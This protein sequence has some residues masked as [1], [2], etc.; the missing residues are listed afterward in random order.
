MKNSWPPMHKLGKMRK[1]FDHKLGLFFMRP[2][3]FVF[4]LNNFILLISILFF[5]ST[6]SKYA[7]FC[8]F[9]YK[10]ND[11][12]LNHAWKL[13]PHAMHLT[14]LHVLVAG[15]FFIYIS[16]LVGCARTIS[17]ECCVNS[18]LRHKIKIYIFLVKNF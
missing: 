11:C 10:V 1:S 2:A 15:S 7:W 6:H 18:V 13:C 9:H 4:L 17:I 5:R 12:N 3:P 8:L 16:R 14:S